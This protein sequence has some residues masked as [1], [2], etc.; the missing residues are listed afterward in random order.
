M[1]LSYTGR[2]GF[3]RFFVGVGFD[4]IR[5]LVARVALQSDDVELVVVN[6]PFISTDYMVWSLVSLS[7]D[8]VVSVIDLVSNPSILVSSVP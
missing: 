7:F 2:V 5:R 3:Y 6:D 8:L 1:Y 4:R